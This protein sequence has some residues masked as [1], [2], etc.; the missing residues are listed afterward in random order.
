L[1]DYLVHPAILN[2][3]LTD[4]DT[5]WEAIKRSSSNDIT[6]TMICKSVTEIPLKQ[7]SVATF[8]LNDLVENI[9]LLKT[10]NFLCTKC[11]SHTVDGHYVEHTYLQCKR[12]VKSWRRTCP[13]NLP[14]ILSILNRLVFVI[15][16]C[17]GSWFYLYRQVKHLNI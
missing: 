9:S 12:N 17:F 3:V 2:D 1:S 6:Q 10:S 16:Q 15:T 5:K 4:C 8:L 14:N 13:I 11:P 7:Q